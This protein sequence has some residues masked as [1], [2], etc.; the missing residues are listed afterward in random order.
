VNNYQLNEYNVGNEGRKKCWIKTTK[1][2]SERTSSDWV[3]PIEV[4]INGFK[5]KVVEI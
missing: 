2:E 1:T 4:K 5:C 3:I